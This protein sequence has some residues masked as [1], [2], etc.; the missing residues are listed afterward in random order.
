[1]KYALLLATL[2]L[3][4]QLHAKPKKGVVISVDLSPAGGFEA[5]SGRLKG[6]KFFKKGDTYEVKNVYVPTK[7]LKTGIDLRDEHLHKRLGKED[8][9]VVE[10]KGKG[11]KGSG[12]IKINGVTKPF[13]FSYKKLSS[14]YI[15][16]KFDLSLKSFNI[17]DISYMSVGVKDKVTVKVIAKYKTSK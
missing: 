1:M 9:M 16:A 5:K 11:G 4:F 7:S 10:A 2:L 13:K 17:K 12:K 3:S 8:V 15:E 14:K 6:G